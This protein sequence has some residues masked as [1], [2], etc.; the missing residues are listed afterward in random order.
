MKRNIFTVILMSLSSGLLAQSFV[1]NAL[2]FSRIQPGGSARIQGLGGA[3][4]ALGG[5]Y[6]SALSNP[7]GLGM[8]NRSEVTFS[9]AV[10]G[11][12]SSSSYFGNSTSDGRTTFNIPGFSYVQKQTQQKGKFL[13]GAFA[14]AYTRTN[15]LNTRYFYQNDNAESSILDYFIEDAYNYSP[16][17][18]LNNGSDSYNLT[19]LAYENFLIQ[20]YDDNGQLFWDSELY[21]F[22][23]NTGEYDYPT[24]N[25]SEEVLRKGAQNQL[26]FSYGGN[27]DDV[28]FFGASIGVASIRFNQEQTFSE[29]NFRYSQ[30]PGFNPITRFQANENFEIEGSGV[31][32][33]IGAIYR[34]VEFVQ[35]G[36]S[37]ATPTI[38]NITD[39]YTARIESRWNNFDYFGDGDIILANEF[40][41]FDVPIISEYDLVT[42][43]KASV[44]ISLMSEYGFISGD[45]EF[46]NYGK[47]KYSS[48]VAGE[49]YRPENE[50]IKAFYDNVVNI[51]A[52][53]E[54]RYEIFRVRGGYSLQP[55]PYQESN[56]INRNI[57]SVSGGLGIRT[58][59]F[60]VDFAV[61]HS[62][63]DGRRVPYFA[64][65]IPTPVA[66]QTFKNTNYMF[67]VGFPF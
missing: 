60:F 17:S 54:F 48:N 18:M 21:A 9:M 7:A 38:Y 29:S 3:Q 22:D 67:T 62:Q 6:S 42:P 5:D 34:P 31:N 16:S 58:S 55:N 53:G 13:G 4:V 1:D 40:A 65:N 26:T 33:T 51:R 41:E 43:T 46:V 28:L 59:S 12:N 37:L 45:V 20:D 56:G 66:T 15:N 19:A 63:T 25:Q 24:V 39:S 14:I 47:A 61:V 27:Y 49:S 32:F 57:Q 8:Y 11:N 44:G 36:F 23:G 64:E 52:G 10:T 30:T 35:V 50:D 2:L